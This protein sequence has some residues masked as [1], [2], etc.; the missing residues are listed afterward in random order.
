MQWGLPWPGEA[1]AAEAEAAGA[2]AFC[3]GEFADISAYVTATEMAHSTAAAMIGPGIAYA[4]ARSPFVHAA[5]VRHLSKRA[6]GRVFLGLGA[7]TPRMN[8]D[9]FGV[10]ADHPAPRMGELIEAIRAYLHAEN[11]ETVRY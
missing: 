6:A 2:T 4:F 7:G 8:R 3:S 1:M 9:W 5:A 11:G 10:D